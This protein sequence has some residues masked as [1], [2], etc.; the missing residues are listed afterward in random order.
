VGALLDAPW[1]SASGLTSG[2]ASG[3]GALLAG[4]RGADAPLLTG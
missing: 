3:L 2:L 1:L 4:V